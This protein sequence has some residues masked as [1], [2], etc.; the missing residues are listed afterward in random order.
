MKTG[1]IRRRCAYC[2]KELKL[3]PIG[4]KE[5]DMTEPVFCSKE[6][7]NRY[8]N[9]EL[10]IPITKRHIFF[11][12][13]F[14]GILGLFGAAMFS[15]VMFAGSI[16]QV[17]PENAAI[18]DPSEKIGEIE[19]LVR[20]QEEGKA[21]DFTSAFYP[22]DPMETML[23]I[24]MENIFNRFANYGEEVLYLVQ[25][26]VKTNADIWSDYTSPLLVRMINGQPQVNNYHLP[27]RVYIKNEHNEWREMKTNRAHPGNLIY[28]PQDKKAKKPPKPVVT[29]LLD[30]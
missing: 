23:S 15:Q 4:G 3:K 2:M 8:Y 24:P 22:V 9:P 27:I 10:D 29:L 21:E 16:F 20:I 7:E 26:R 14:P 25:F 19:V 17:I 12:L 5:V 28:W 1:K 6:H 13:L 30:D 11:G 18:T